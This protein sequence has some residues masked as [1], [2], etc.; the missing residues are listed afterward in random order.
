MMADPST[1]GRSA[2]DALHASP[3]AQYLNRAHARTFSLNI[4][5]MNALELREAVIRAHDAEL[6]LDLFFEKN[7][8]AS[9]QAHREISRHLHNFLAAAKTLVDHTRALVAEH[10]DGTPLQTAYQ[11][12]LNAGPGREPVVAFIHDLRNYMLHRGP[13]GTS[14]FVRFDRNDPDTDATIK[15]GIHLE[16]TSLAAWPKLSA[17]A[18][19]FIAD[20]GD[21]LDFRQ[22]VDD[23]LTHVRALH[24][25]LDQELETLHREDLIETARLEAELEQRGRGMAP[26]SLPNPETASVERFQWSPEHAR[27]IDEAAIKLV[28]KIRALRFAARPSP[29]FPSQRHAAATITPDDLVDTPVFTGQDADG[30]RVVAFIHTDTTP[31]GLA[32][33]DF[34]GVATLADLVRETPWAA[35]SLGQSF[36]QQTFIIWARSAFSGSD[37]ESYSDALS[38]AARNTVRTC[39]VLAPVAYLEVQSAF[40]LGPV[41]IEPLGI[42]LIE[43]FRSR[44]GEPSPEQAA[45]VDA[46]LLQMERDFVGH[47]AIAIELIAEPHFAQEKALLIAQD[48]VALLRVFCPESIVAALLCPMALMG[49]EIMPSSKL[50]VL[51]ENEASLTDSLLVKDIVHWR[52]SD[53]ARERIM[54][55]GLALAGRLIA[56]EGLTPFALDVRASLIRFSQGL[57][58]P[59]PLVR[60]TQSFA[61]L[62][63]I[64]LR[65]SVEPREPSVARRMELLFQSPPGEP[66]GVGETVM[67]GYALL[68]SP[69][70]GPL[71]SSETDLL[72]ALA[73]YAQ[74]ALLTALRN[75]ERFPTRSTFLDALDEPRA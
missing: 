73:A 69:K 4:L 1:L 19:Q 25:W 35:Q 52:L 15:T 60:L 54:E 31:Y 2:V 8:E 22:F 74:P 65:H 61:A 14:M 42:Q 12:R 32:E 21:K 44:G 29:S 72:G 16:L 5:E 3:G 9:Q 57:T 11:D 27:A 7:R 75:I 17:R 48:C 67:R 34:S 66:G 39:R 36:I 70:V 38:A 40:Q 68:K 26:P 30:M 59:D 58:S 43:D 62:E 18:R 41:A 47:A 24:A 33:D 46:L 37:A 55:Q 71:T 53:A 10:Y 50:I 64:L 20:K 49:A 63:A 6:S 13:P 28:S 23:Y 51:S 45:D 56:I